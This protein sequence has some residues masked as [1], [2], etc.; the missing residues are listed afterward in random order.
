MT[1]MKFT[2]SL[3]LSLTCWK[4]MLKGLVMQ[5]CVLFFV[6]ALSVFAFGS[7]ANEVLTAF[8]EVGIS[9]TIANAVQTVVTGNLTSQAIT[10][11]VNELA[12][13]FAG[14]ID[15]IPN[16]FNRIEFAY[17]IFVLI[18][19]LFYFLVKLP[20]MP[21]NYSIGEF[22]QTNAKRPITWYVF[23]KLSKNLGYVGYR[24][25]YEGVFNMLIVF[26]FVGFY[27]MSSIV[28]SHYAF[29]FALFIAIVLFTAKSTLLAFWL[30]ALTTNEWSVRRSMSQGIAN[31]ATCFWHVF[32]KFIVVNVIALEA[33]ILL[34][35][36]FPH[37]VTVAVSMLLLFIAGYV[38][39]CIGMVEYFEAT[40]RKY[41]YKKLKSFDEVMA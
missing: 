1:Q 37:Q 7:F 2:K 14:V 28:L 24:M 6:V 21:V 39:Q 25:I 8:Q 15:E 4:T 32:Y 36:F 26:S 12:Q 16:L 23:K 34:N 40:N 9:Q 5:L 29:Y 10:R 31:V 17:L 20:S 11:Y 30:P 35:Y 3:K 13:G 41:F 18:L 33:V 38:N 19:C 27:I 22:M